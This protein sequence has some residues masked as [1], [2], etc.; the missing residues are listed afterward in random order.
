MLPSE[1]YK[2]KFG[3][4]IILSVFMHEYFKDKSE[5]ISRIYGR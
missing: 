1:F 5:E 2:L 4:R 3:E